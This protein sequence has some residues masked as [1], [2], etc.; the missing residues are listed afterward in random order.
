[1]AAGK[2]AAIMER[3]GN[4]PISEHDKV[5]RTGRYMTY[6]QRMSAH[7]QISPT[8]KYNACD[9]NYTVMHRLTECGQ[10]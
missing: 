5:F 9:V 2:L 1:V 4:S 6:F 7:N 8:D 10:G 3:I